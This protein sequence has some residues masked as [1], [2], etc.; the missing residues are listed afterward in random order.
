MAHAVFADRHEGARGDIDRGL[1]ARAVRQS[2]GQERVRRRQGTLG[3]VRAAS[4]V[5]QQLAQFLV[6][7]RHRRHPHPPAVGEVQVGV[8]VA[9]DEDVLHA[10][11]VQVGLEPTGAELQV[12][13][14]LGHGGVLGGRRGHAALDGHGVRPDRDLFVDQR[15][16]LL[17]LRGG[18][19]TRLPAQQLRQS[20]PHLLLDQPHRLVVHDGLGHRH[21]SDHAHRRGLPDARRAT[22]SDG[23]LGSRVRHYH[24]VG[25]NGPSAH[26]WPPP[27][28][29]HRGGRAW[30]AGH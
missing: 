18:R 7:V 13:H 14:R 27:A 30:H 8:R 26:R 5:P 20:L 11:V 21:G 3:L 17:L 23:C 9:V 12:E 25:V 22:M 15:P 6:A 29:R 24:G 2:Q 16:A 1:Q 19:H 28:Q 10:R 4:E